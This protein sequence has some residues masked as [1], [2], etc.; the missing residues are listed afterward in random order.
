MNNSDEYTF[1]ELLDNANEICSNRKICQ[2]KTEQ[3]KQYNTLLSKLEES[4]SKSLSKK[5]KGNAL[6]NLVNYLLEVSGDLFQVYSNV[7]TNTNE[8]DQLIKLKPKGKI[9]N[10]HGVLD[11]R[12]KEFICECKNF[13]SKVSVTYVG[14]LFSLMRSC[15]ISFGVLFSYSGVTGKKWNSAAGLVKKIYMKS[16]I[17]NNCCTIIDFNMND[18]KMISNGSNFLDIIEDKITMLKYDTDFESKIQP[19][20]AEKK[21]KDLMDS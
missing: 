15:G 17:N 4:H 13:E 20:C 7:R 11:N 12:Y 9:L 10:S 3:K 14:K 8:I 2:L 1:L 5:E 18:F 6:E 19:H 21:F 16:Q